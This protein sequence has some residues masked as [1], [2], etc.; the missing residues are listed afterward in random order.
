MN[1]MSYTIFDADHMPDIDA[2]YSRWAK[3]TTQK[4]VTHPRGDE[5]EKGVIV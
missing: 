5:R 1:S 3:D 4:C 2:R